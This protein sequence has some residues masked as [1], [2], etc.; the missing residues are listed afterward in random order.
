MSPHILLVEDNPSDAKLAL[1]AFK[2]SR[3]VHQITHVC[4]GEAALELLMGKAAPSELQT[5]P[6]PALVLLDL[7][8]PKLDGLGVLRKLRAHPETALLP[9]IILTSSHLQED[10]TQSYACGA[11]AYVRKPIDFETF[12]DVAKTVGTFWLLVNEAP[13]GEEALR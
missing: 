12:T 9:V 4:D 11:N 2:R 6:R 13:T 3:V 7:N 1:A 10:V 8:L 5:R